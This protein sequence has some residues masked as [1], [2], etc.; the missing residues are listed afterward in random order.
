MIPQYHE[1]MRTH[2]QVNGGARMSETMRRD[3]V[4]ELASA[5]IL[6]MTDAAIGW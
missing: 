1:D 6:P 4:A 5:R 2:P 3:Q